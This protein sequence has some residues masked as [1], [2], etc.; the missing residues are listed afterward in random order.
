MG[1]TPSAESAD[2]PCPKLKV[3]VDRS[4]LD[5]DARDSYCTS[6][7]LARR[8]L[9]PAQRALEALVESGVPGNIAAGLQLSWFY[10]E[11]NVG[12]VDIAMDIDPAA[13]RFGPIYITVS[14]PSGCSWI[15][16]SNQSW[17]VIE[18]GARAPDLV[19][20]CCFRWSFATHS[21]G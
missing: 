7:P 17:A 10:S 12:V 4:G 21:T 2:K 6:V 8:A 3:K 18:A 5:V 14:A 20:D 13:M 19:R 1:Y 15:S 16:T 11:P 9:N